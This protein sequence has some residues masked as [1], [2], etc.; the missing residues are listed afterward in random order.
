MWSVTS[1]FIQRNSGIIVI[2]TLSLVLK[3][4]Y[5]FVYQGLPTWDQLTV[6]NYYH[7]NWAL[8]IAD[9]WMFLTASF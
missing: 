3:L 8:D 5:L 2:V 9:L 6:D 4:L 1:K 7:H